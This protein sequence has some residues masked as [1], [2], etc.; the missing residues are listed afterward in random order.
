MPIV[1]QILDQEGG[2]SPPL[3]T[4]ESVK[5]Y[6]AAMMPRGHF[7]VHEHPSGPAEHDT[8]PWGVAIKRDNGEVTLTQRQLAS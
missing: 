7:D 3:G 8:T 5:K 2:W 1:Y 4:L 6:V